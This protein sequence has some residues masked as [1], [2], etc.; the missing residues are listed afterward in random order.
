[1]D[2]SDTYYIN[3]LPESFPENDDSC[4]SMLYAYLDRWLCNVAKKASSPKSLAEILNGFSHNPAEKV[5]IAEH[6]GGAEL[7]LPCLEAELDVFDF[8]IHVQ[9]DGTISISGDI[10]SPMLYVEAIDNM[11][12]STLYITKKLCC[13]LECLHLCRN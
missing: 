13:Y 12:I 4:I 11:E 7:T 10:F 3:K 2:L 5:E 8:S 1:M 9:F 6:Q